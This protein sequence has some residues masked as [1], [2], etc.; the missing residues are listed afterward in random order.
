MSFYVKNMRYLLSILLFMV[1]FGL[2][3]QEIFPEGCVPFVV[4]NDLVTLS[5][6]K[7]AI[8]MMHNLSTMDVWITH[9]VQKTGAGAGWSSRVQAGNW[10]ALVLRSKAFKLSCI[11]SRP[12]HEQQIP[13]S[14]VLAVCKWPNVSIPEKMSGTFWAG[15]DMSLSPLKAYIERR[16]FVLSA[17]IE[18]Q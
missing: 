3:A 16:G 18:T 11:E 6:E 5:T 8:V 4:E 1:G 10:S 17:P 13:C 14:G 7:P 12:G 9:T 15:E 2:H